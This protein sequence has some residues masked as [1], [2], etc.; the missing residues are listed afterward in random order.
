[1]NHF[2]GMKSFEHTYEMGFLGTIS[3]VSLYWEIVFVL[4]SG[5]YVRFIFWNVPWVEMYVGFC[6]PDLILCSC[7]MGTELVIRGVLM[8]SKAVWKYKINVWCFCSIFVVFRLDIIKILLPFSLSTKDMKE[9]IPYGSLTCLCQVTRRLI[10]E[11]G[12]PRNTS[13]SSLW[14]LS[15]NSCVHRE[16]Y[17]PWE[18][19]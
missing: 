6:A 7:I 10:S 19:Q 13:A 5:R 18:V 11:D 4:P 15:W 3:D 1:M 2:K 8:F 9:S 16:T 14:L 17:S 12:C